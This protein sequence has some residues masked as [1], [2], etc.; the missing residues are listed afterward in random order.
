MLYVSGCVQAWAGEIARD[1]SPHILRMLSGRGEGAPCRSAATTICRAAPS[2]K[3]ASV[4]GCVAFVKSACTSR[5]RSGDRAPASGAC[6][7]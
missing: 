7:R 2:F 5:A 6:L 4:F 1:K 3:R